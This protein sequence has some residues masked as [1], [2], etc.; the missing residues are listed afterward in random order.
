MQPF[1]WPEAIKQMVQETTHYGDRLFNGTWPP[2][3]IEVIAIPKEYE[4]GIE[5][6]EDLDHFVFNKY[7]WIVGKLKSVVHEATPSSYVTFLLSKV[8]TAG[9]QRSVN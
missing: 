5:L 6:I 1:V 2:C 7:K 9:I 3:S 4:E 8:A